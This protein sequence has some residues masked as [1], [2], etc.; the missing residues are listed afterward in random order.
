MKSLLALAIFYSSALAA[1]KD[2]RVDLAKRETAKLY[3]G[4]I[5]TQYGIDKVNV[6]E[7]KDGFFV[8]QVVAKN[9]KNYCFIFEVEGDGAISIVATNNEIEDVF[10]REC[11]DK[12]TADELQQFKQ[13][14]GWPTQ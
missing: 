13:L 8:T 5:S 6:I 3:R 9:K 11:T 1:P 2:S 7:Q 14:N 12:P 4:H 10:V